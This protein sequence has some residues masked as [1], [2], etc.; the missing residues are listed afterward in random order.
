MI[1][2]D[3]LFTKTNINN[4]FLAQYYFKVNDCTQ[5]I[6]LQNSRQIN[7]K[8]IQYCS[9]PKIHTIQ[10]TISDLNC[11]FGMQNNCIARLLGNYIF[12]FYIANR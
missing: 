2:Y 8:F 9:Q 11:L 7:R 10:I 12:Q 4:L 3:L 1:P 5:L 6:I